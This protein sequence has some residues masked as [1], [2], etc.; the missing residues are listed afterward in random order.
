MKK[1]IKKSYKN[2]K[3][4]ISG[5]TTD[6]ELE[7]Y[8]VSVTQNYFEYIIKKHETLT[9]KLPIRIHLNRIENRITFKI[10]PDTILSFQCHKQ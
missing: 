1:N 8:S 10:S 4:K 7:S 6:E 2:T 3:F 9:D 5:L